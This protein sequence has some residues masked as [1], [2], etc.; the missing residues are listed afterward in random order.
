MQTR[1]DDEQSFVAAALRKDGYPRPTPRCPLRRSAVISA[2][3]DIAI[4]SGVMAEIETGRRP[5]AVE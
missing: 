4:S 2:K 5:D 1:N 3:T